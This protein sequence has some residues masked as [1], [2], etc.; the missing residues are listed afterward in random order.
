MALEGP[1]GWLAGRT[2]HAALCLLRIP[3]R[4]PFPCC[5][6]QPSRSLA[7]PAPSLSPPHTPPLCQPPSLCSL[8]APL[9]PP[10]P[11][12][13]QQLRP[14]ARPPARPALQAQV[15]APRRPP[16][17][18]VYP[19][20]RLYAREQ[21]GGWLRSAGPLAACRLFSVLLKDAAST[22]QA[23]PGARRGLRGRRVARRQPREG[24]T[25]GGDQ[26]GKG[27]G[28]PPAVCAARPAFAGCGLY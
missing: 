9:P 16:P 6:Q 14:H 25:G 23:R 21:P 22:L 24:Q 26:A 20:P 12:P 5:L 11:R 10:F 4:L 17:G 3:S 15:R 19:P 27:P 18:F 13:Q 28:G 1:L 7:C 8:P 2:L